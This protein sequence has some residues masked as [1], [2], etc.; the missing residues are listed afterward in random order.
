MNIPLPNDSPK[1]PPAHAAHGRVL[2]LPRLELEAL[3]S[4]KSTRRHMLQEREYVSYQ[5][6]ILIAI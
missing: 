1:N 6:I 5:C 3:D 4:S 2:G